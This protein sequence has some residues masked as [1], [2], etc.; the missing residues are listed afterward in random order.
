MR[1][2]ECVQAL[3]RMI[4]DLAEALAAALPTSPEKSEGL[5]KLLAAKDLFIRAS[6]D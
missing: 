2:Q 1:E 4:S 3:C 6:K 5:D